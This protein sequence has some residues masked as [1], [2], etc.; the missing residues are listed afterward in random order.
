ML[1]HVLQLL[2]CMTVQ[3]DKQRWHFTHNYYCTF[4]L[5]I[6]LHTSPPEERKY[7]LRI[8]WSFVHILNALRYL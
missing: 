1:K 7:Y 6:K 4:P 3:D 8:S 5:R 2:V